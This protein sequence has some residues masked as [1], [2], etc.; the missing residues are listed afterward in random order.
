MSRRIVG[1]GS[2]VVDVFFRLRAMPVAGTK[3]YFHDPLR[4][5]EGK[6]VGGVTLNHLSWAA[7]LGAQR[8]MRRRGAAL[9]L[10][11]AAHTVAWSV[12]LVA[13]VSNG[14]GGFGS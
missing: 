2:N 4:A 6:V 12:G 3:G 1:L 11:V 8:Q 14:G 7:A 5:E 9:G 13:W 10:A